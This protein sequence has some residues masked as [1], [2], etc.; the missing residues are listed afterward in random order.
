MTAGTEA[1][2]GVLA[3]EDGEVDLVRGEVRRGAAVVALTTK[4]RDL[5][6][7]LANRPDEV[8]A[9]DDAHRAVWGMH[10][11]VVSRAIDNTMTRLRA[12]VEADPRAPRHL[13][14]VY[15]AG[16][17]FVPKAPLD[18]EAWVGRAAEASRGCASGW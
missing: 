3:L 7:Y 1:A 18:P 16:Y 6:V 15:G 10:A 9:R 17:R 11:A 14:T 12:K 4:E 8:V 5:L 13:L 2:A